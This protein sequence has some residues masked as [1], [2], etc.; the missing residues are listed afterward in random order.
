MMVSRDF[1]MKGVSL[2]M[3]L[4]FTSLPWAQMDW[5]CLVATCS[6]LKVS[7]TSILLG[8]G[9]VIGLALGAIVVIYIYVIAGIS[10]V[11]GA[12]I[13]SIPSILS[14]RVRRGWSIIDIDRDNLGKCIEYV[15]PVSHE[16]SLEERNTFEESIYESSS[17]FK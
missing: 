14:S 7:A 10:G 3:L 11:E 13:R 17:R 12:T 16:G 5:R 2:A 6:I 4:S 1:F 8:L 15:E 9:F